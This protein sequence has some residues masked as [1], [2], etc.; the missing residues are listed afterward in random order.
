MLI[1]VNVT[2]YF[3]HVFFYSNYLKNTFVII[4]MYTSIV[5]QCKILRLH[6][7]KRGFVSFNKNIR[8]NF[9]HLV[10]I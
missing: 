6:H 7:F 10:N 4:H 2:Y 8:Y 5:T 9:S 3:I 1:S